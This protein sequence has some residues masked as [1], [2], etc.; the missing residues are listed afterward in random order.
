V[1]TPIYF[2]KEQCG[3]TLEAFEYAEDL[4]RHFYKLVYRDWLGLYY[5]LKTLANLQIH[6]ITDQAFAQLARYEMAM[7][8]GSRKT[9][10]TDFYRIC[11]QDHKILDAIENRQDGIDFHPLILYVV[12][13]ELIHIIRFGKLL[14]WY[15]IPQPSDE[16]ETRVHK[17]TG[18]ILKNVSMPG[19]DRVLN[20][21]RVCST[22]QNGLSN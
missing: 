19:L 15:E 6:E 4:V 13:H 16:E 3:W 10:I 7:P 12:T 8:K 1:G 14:K 21:Y 17:V 5:D 20:N 18:E 11:I 9:G 2:N 22:A